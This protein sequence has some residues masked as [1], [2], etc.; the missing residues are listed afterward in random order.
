[1]KA[2]DWFRRPNIEDQVRAA[3]TFAMQKKQENERIR[4]RMIEQ[5]IKLN[6]N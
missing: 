2:M 1:M 3:Y 5:G 6:L 4:K